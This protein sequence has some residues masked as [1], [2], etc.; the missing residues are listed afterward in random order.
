MTE[1]AVGGDWVLTARPAPEAVAPANASSTATASAGRG[2]RSSRWTRARQAAARAPPPALP[3]GAALPPRSP[4]RRSSSSSRAQAAPSGPRRCASGRVGLVS[5][6]ACG[7]GR[8]ALRRVDPRGP[9]D[10]GPRTASTARSRNLGAEGCG[11]CC[12][13]SPARG[14]RARRTWSA[15]VARDLVG[16]ARIACLAFDRLPWASPAALGGRRPPRAGPRAPVRP[17]RRPRHT[18]LGPSA[19]TWGLGIDPTARPRARRSCVACSRKPLCRIHRFVDASN[20][21]APDARAL[22]RLRPR[23]HRRAARVTLGHADEGLRASRGRLGRGRPSSPTARARSA[24]R[25]PTRTHADR[26]ARR[27]LVVLTSRPPWRTRRSPLLDS[28]TRRSCARAAEGDGTTGR[29]VTDKTSSPEP[30]ASLEAPLELSG[31]SWGRA[32]RGSTSGQR[33][34]RRFGSAGACAAPAHLRSAPPRASRDQWLFLREPPHALAVR[35]DRRCSA[36]SSR[37]RP[38]DCLRP[39][40]RS[41]GSSGRSPLRRRRSRR[42]RDPLRDA[43]LLLR[44]HRA[45]PR[46]GVQA[47]RRRGLSPRRRA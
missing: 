33:E 18:A 35:R 19:T 4:T 38:T 36:P 41:R 31:A 37:P 24:T 45:G 43:V 32:R 29:A 15:T 14:Q 7:A 27:A 5:R 22:R 16:K 47:H 30:T 20:L 6:P 1:A 3:R 12:P 23:P 44:G 13:T 39:P 21:L 9:R 42:R 40:P 8:P 26:P 2:P 17:G 46:R 34:F 25:P 10:A 11:S 28:V